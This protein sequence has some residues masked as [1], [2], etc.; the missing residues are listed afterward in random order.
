MPILCFQK[1][2]TEIGMKY[3]RLHLVGLV[4]QFIGDISLSSM[5]SKDVSSKKS[6]FRGTIC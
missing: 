6:E 3:G 1:I 5:I 2:V 4:G